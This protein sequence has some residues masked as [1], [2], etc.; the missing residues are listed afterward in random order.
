MIF[1]GHF[2]KLFFLIKQHFQLLCEFYREGHTC[3]CSPQDEL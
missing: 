2:L 3:L 1:E